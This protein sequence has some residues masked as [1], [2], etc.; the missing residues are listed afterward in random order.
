MFE[1]LGNESWKEIKFHPVAEQGDPIKTIA[2]LQELYGC[3][4]SHVALQEAFFP[5][6]FA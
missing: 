1:H 2:I 3:S 6:N 5:D 4:D